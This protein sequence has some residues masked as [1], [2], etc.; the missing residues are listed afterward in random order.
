MNFSKLLNNIGMFFKNNQFLKWIL[1]IFIFLFFEYY[2]YLTDIL[3][4]RNL[5]SIARLVYIIIC[6]VADLLCFFIY[7]KIQKTDKNNYLKMYL[8]V[9]IFIGV[10]Y[11]FCT[12]ILEGTDE[13]VH[14]LRAYQISTG[15][16][17][18]KDPQIDKTLFPNEILK[19]YQKDRVK[20]YKLS[21][22]FSKPDYKMETELLK[23]NIPVQYSPVQYIPQI[24][25]IWTAGILNLSPF[26]MVM[27]TRLM[28]FIT[29]IVFSY[30]AIKTMPYKKN[31]MAI[32]CLAPAVLSLV[33]TAS[34]DIFLNS[35]ALLYIA[36]ILKIYD[37]KKE[38][39]TKEKV[40]LTILSIGISLCK[41]VYFALTLL[42][43]IIPKRSF[44]DN[45]TKKLLFI[46]IVIL[47][48]LSI[49]LWWYI[50]SLGSGINIGAS[51]QL[52]FI[53]NN[54]IQ[55]IFI[56]F[57]TFF[58]NFYYYL[59]NF[60]AGQE[61]CFGKARISSCLVILYMAITIFSLFCNSKKVKITPLIKLLF[62][63]IF[64]MVLIAVSTIM[65]IDWTPRHWA[66]GYYIIR[67]VQARYLIMFLPLLVLTFNTDMFKIKNEKRLFIVA[68]ILNTLIFI[69]T[70]ASLLTRK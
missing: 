44:K 15:H 35:M 19:L 39:S 5:V 58:D 38:L 34:S 36:Y 45:I 33:T 62:W 70:F 61:M 4:I 9:G 7:K 1:L 28:N 43:F 51:E 22:M 46:F 63:G 55:Y 11:M 26:M 23:R 25:G 42:L 48:S 24:I 59:S 14:F 21:I 16:I 65:Y 10:L 49:D 17:I 68:A 60:V 40:L 3:K 27:L 2:V 37:S 69:Q 56:F 8:I 30:L 54:P 47:V 31:F 52:H 18:V 32:L 66:I 20:D 41:T 50:A 53:L 6:L 64:F 13:P 67:G 12:P 57:R 29:W